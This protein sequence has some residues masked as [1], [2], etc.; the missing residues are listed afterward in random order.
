VNTSVVRFSRIVL[1][2]RSY[3]PRLIAPVVA[4]G[5]FPKIDAT[6]SSS[7]RLNDASA[8]AQ[9]LPPP[10]RYRAI[11]SSGAIVA[12]NP[13]RCGSAP[14]FRTTSSLNRSTDSI[15]STP[16]LFAARLCSSSTIIRRTPVKCRRI[17]A[18]ARHSAKLSGVVTKIC[19]AH[20]TIPA[21]SR[22]ELSPVRNPT[23]TPPVRSS[24]F[25]VGPLVIGI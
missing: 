11:P 7:R 20:L 25:S 12:D 3:T 5:D 24:R 15:K 17:P 8:I 4:N 23:R 18:L 19:G 22:A 16:R 13:I 6:S 1:S 21:L 10:T 14:P 9:S 2:S